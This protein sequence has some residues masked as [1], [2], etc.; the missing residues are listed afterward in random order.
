MI[1]RL[2]RENPKISKREIQERAK[3]GKKAVEYNI[4]ML[5]KQ[6]ILKRIGPARGGYWMIKRK[7]ENE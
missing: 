2:I 1:L 3:L 4:E 5:K 6:G 7:R